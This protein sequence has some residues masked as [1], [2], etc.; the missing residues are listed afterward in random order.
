MDLVVQYR[1]C[2]KSP[3]DGYEESP[4]RRVESP[5]RVIISHD[6]GD[7]AL[8][9]VEGIRIAEWRQEGLSE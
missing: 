2:Y 9:D 8:A 7:L 3:C 5:H 4:P 6:K 1:L